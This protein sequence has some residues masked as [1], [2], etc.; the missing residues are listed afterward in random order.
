MRR[1]TNI[2]GP[3]F[4]GGRDSARPRGF[5]DYRYNSKYTT[6]LRNTLVKSSRRYYTCPKRKIWLVVANPLDYRN[7]WA[8]GLNRSNKEN[9]ETVINS[10]KNW[11]Q[12]QD[13]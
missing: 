1:F 2:V 8:F 13:F 11:R 10:R 4:F 9:E 3:L 7:Q 5:A 6:R 12:G